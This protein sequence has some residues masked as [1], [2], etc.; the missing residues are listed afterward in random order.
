MEDASAVDLDRVG[1][2]WFYSTDHVDVDLVSVR[3]YQVSTLDP[4]VE[5]GEKRRLSD[6]L[7][8]EPIEQVRNRESGIVP[9]V[10][11]VEG[12]R[13]LYNEN[14]PY[15][16]S[17]KQRNEYGEYLKSLEPWERKVLERAVADDDFIYFVDFE[18]KGGLLTPLPLLLE[19]QDGTSERYDVPAEI[20]R[21]NSD[22]VTKLF[23]LNKR[24]RGIELDPLHQTADVYRANN[25]YPRKVLPSRLE[26][27]KQESTTR[28]LMKD[29]LVE[30]KAKDEAAV[31]S[32]NVPLGEPD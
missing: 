23:V 21:R 31:E 9:R 13:D 16:V 6:E 15:T 5:S 7:T 24:L 12:L 32:G 29:M 30:L 14:D 18:N 22:R 28:D 17:N 19:F 27:F 26:L 8:R 20:W 11:R 4:E 1:R 2:G 3:E 25:Y 10:E